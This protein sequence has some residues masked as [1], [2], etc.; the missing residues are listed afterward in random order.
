MINLA[1]MTGGVATET[2]TALRARAKLA[3]VVAGKATV[4]AIQGAIKS[5]K[6][7]Q[8]G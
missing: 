7:F 8:T 1:G 5:V 6:I 2:D 3:V 4:A